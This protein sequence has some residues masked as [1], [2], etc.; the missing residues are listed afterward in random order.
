MTM[1]KGER[2]KF[3]RNTLTPSFSTGK[4]KPM[5]NIFNNVTDTL[6]GK[7]RAA[8]DKGNLIDF[9]EYVKFSHFLHRFTIN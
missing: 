8:A 2:W 5:V 1:V 9:V 4:M 3:I 7:L 6:I